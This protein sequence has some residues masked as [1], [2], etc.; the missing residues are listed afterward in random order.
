MLEHVFD[1]AVEGS[2]ECVPVVVASQKVRTLM[3]RHLEDELDVVLVTNAHQF[4]RR[5]VHGVQTNPLKTLVVLVKHAL[6]FGREDETDSPDFTA[7]LLDQNEPNECRP[8]PRERVDRNR[9][10]RKCD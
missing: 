9:Y 2:D 4:I 6:S 5:Q 10:R 8:E 7:S 1:D 3:H